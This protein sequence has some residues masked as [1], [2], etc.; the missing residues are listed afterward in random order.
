MGDQVS[1][2]SPCKGSLCDTSVFQQFNEQFKQHIPPMWEHHQKFSAQ[3]DRFPACTRYRFWLPRH[4]GST[5]GMV[6]T[7][8]R[9]LCTFLLQHPRWWLELR[10]VITFF[11]LA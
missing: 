3:I 9:I 5:L 8:Q 10:H 7:Q 1:V 2:S 6:A 4:I 11:E